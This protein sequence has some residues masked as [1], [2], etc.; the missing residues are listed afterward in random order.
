MREF[1][2]KMA[3]FFDVAAGKCVHIRRGKQVFRLELCTPDSL[4]SNMCTQI[5][6]K[7]CTQEPKTENMCTQSK[8]ACTQDNTNVYTNKVTFARALIT[9]YGCGCEK[10]GKE[11]LCKTHNRY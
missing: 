11:M 8:E 2:A 1:R 5:D 9:H 6:T 3:S 10:E 7:A 4:N